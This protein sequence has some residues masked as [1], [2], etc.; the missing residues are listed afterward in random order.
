VGLDS[1]SLPFYK[2]VWRVTLVLVTIGQKEEEEEEEE[3]FGKSSLLL[4]FVVRSV[5]DESDLFDRRRFPL[6]LSLSFVLSLSLSLSLSPS[7]N[8]WAGETIYREK[9]KIFRRIWR[10]NDFNRFKRRRGRK[11][12]F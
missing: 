10:A 3:V 6:S 8:F 5:D 9:E 7:G 1:L 12:P 2:V 11:V 4:F